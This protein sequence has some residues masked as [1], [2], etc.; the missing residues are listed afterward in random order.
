MR[1]SWARSSTSRCG[2]QVPEPGGRGHVAGR[3]PPSGGRCGEAGLAGRGIRRLRNHSGLAH[4]HAGLCARAG[5]ELVVGGYSFKIEKM[6]RSRISGN[7]GAEAACRRGS[8]PRPMPARRPVSRGKP[9]AARRRR[10][11]SPARGA[12]LVRRALT[13]VHGAPVTLAGARRRVRRRVVRRVEREGHGNRKTAVSLARC[14]CGGRLR[15]HSDYFGVDAIVVRI[16]TVILSLATTGLAAIAYV[17]LWAVLP[18]P[19]SIQ[20][21]RGDAAGG[22][23]RNVWRHRLAPA[24]RQAG[25]RRRH[26]GSCTHGCLWDV[27]G[28]RPRAARASRRRAR[29]RRAWRSPR[30]QRGGAYLRLA[31]RIGVWRPAAPPPCAP[32]RAHPAHERPFHPFHPRHVPRGRFGRASPCAGSVRRLRSCARRLCRRPR[33]SQTPP[34]PSPVPPRRR[35]MGSEGRLGVRHPPFVLRRA[36]FGGQVRHG[37]GMVAVLAACARH[38]RH[39]AKW[40]SPAS[41][42]GVRASSPADSSCS[43]LGAALLPMRPGRFEFRHRLRLAVANLWPLLVIM[44]GFLVLGGALKSP[45]L[46]LARRP[47]LRRFLRGWLGVVRGAGIDGVLGHRGPFWAAVRLG[48]GNWPFAGNHDS[49]ALRRFR[50]PVAPPA[51]LGVFAFVKRTKR[52]VVFT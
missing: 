7:Q 25:R 3:W 37:G 52:E 40:P 18:K 2:K 36:G 12:R 47:R 5:D 43:C 48:S 42:G 31:G 10:A 29:L 33:R 15:R 46:P 22:A 4:G 9:Q 39:R 32:R 8:G 6:R 50:H 45:P 1:R 17:A 23:F 44:L 19:P 41:G 16:L 38:R 24:H 26:H 27:P 51:P 49:F 21:L 11:P 30:S 14:P 13:R 20:A 35:A 28:C 34:P